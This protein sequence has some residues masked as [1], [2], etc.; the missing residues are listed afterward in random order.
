MLAEKIDYAFLPSNYSEAFASVEGY[1]G[2]SEK[3]KT[4]HEASKQEQHQS[5]SK[6]INEPFTLLFMGVDGT[7]NGIKNMTA[8]GDSLVLVTFN[9]NTLNVT[10]VSIPRDSYVPISCMGGKKN[11]ITPI[12]NDAYAAKTTAKTPLTS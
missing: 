10:M 2:L 3:I 5:S 6:G 9:P 7:G 11:K 4:I 1:Q 12:K 8:N